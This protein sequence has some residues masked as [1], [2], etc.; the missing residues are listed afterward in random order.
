VAGVVG[1]GGAIAIAGLCGIV[2]VICLR[3][4]AVDTAANQSQ[5]RMPEPV[6]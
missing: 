6:G 5:E 4:R 3:P 2:I 1:P